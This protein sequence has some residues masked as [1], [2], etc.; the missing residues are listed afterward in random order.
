MYTP[1]PHKLAVMSDAGS[2]RG[3]EA[4]LP[5]LP[6]G[7]HGLPREFVVENQ[8]RRIAAGMI[9]VVVEVG[10]PAASVTQI[11]AAAGVSR[12]TFYNYYSDKVEAFFDVYGQV[13]DFLCEA[14]VEAEQGERSWAGQVRAALTA[15][16]DCFAT[17][18]DLAAFC[19]LSPPAAG[20]DVAAA[21][22]AFLDRLLE[23]LTDGRPK[24]ARRPSPA[25]SY[26]IMGGLVALILGASESGG[27]QAIRD[28]AP[29]VTELVLTPY[30]G[31]EEAARAAR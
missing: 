5:R 4:G 8:R 22:R 29:E 9:A 15:L 11:V 18:P 17:N 30:L 26:G 12:R 7:R 6:P 20:G 23:I 3:D 21:Y 25:A 1:S 27:P 31:R 24:R 10:Y 16:L 14:M 13:T 19:L 2:G 28:L